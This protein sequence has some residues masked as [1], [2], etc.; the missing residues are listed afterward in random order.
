MPSQEAID[1]QEKQL[2]VWRDQVRLLASQRAMHGD[3]FVPPSIMAGITLAHW[4][5]A[6]C[7]AMLRGWGIP[8]ED[9][10]EDAAPLPVDLPPRLPATPKPTPPSNHRLRFLSGLAA[11]AASVI[12]SKDVFYG[13]GFARRCLVG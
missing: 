10:P 8:I 3:A 1:H 12:R 13:S 6:Q 9:L 5:I 7:K 11:T 4:E 2:Q